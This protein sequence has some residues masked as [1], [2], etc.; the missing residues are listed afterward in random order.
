[1]FAC[2]MLHGQMNELLWWILKSTIED[3]YENWYHFN[4][5]LFNTKLGLVAG[6][7]ILA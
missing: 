3:L 5:C 4:V 2:L 7:L 1:M 6:E